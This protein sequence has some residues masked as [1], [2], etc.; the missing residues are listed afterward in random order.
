MAVIPSVDYH[1]IGK[2]DG[3]TVW[4]KFGELLAKPLQKIAHKRSQLREGGLVWSWARSLL[5]VYR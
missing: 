5:L 4:G 1:S 2:V 3:G